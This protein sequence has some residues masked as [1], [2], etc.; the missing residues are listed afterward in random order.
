MGLKKV[1][2]IAGELT[3][4]IDYIDALLF[5][6]STMEE[7]PNPPL[8]RIVPLCLITFRQ[9]PR[10]GLQAIIAASDRDEETMELLSPYG[11]DPLS[12]NVPTVGLQAITF[13]QGPH[14]GLQA[15]I[16][17]SDCDEEIMEVLPWSPRTR[18][19][20]MLFG[21]QTAPEKAYE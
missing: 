16:A 11:V 7:L 2:Y 3:C 8:P 19:V 5:D 12:K 1:H 13:R 17:A 20:N 4:Y 9:G 6:P 10:V 18:I 14:V 15:I 21:G